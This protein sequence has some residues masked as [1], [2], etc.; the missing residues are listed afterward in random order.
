M[1]RKGDH[2]KIVGLVEGDKE[3]EAI[4]GLKSGNCPIILFI[5]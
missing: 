1:I 2:F 5:I 3:L 4:E